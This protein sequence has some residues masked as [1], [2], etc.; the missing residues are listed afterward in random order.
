[1]EMQQRERYSVLK[2]K[3]TP[4]PKKKKSVSPIFTQIAVS[5]MLIAIGFG[6]SAV[7]S[8]K[9]KPYADMLTSSLTVDGDLGD[10]SEAL[11]TFSIN[12]KKISKKTE[13]F[14]PLKG[15]TITD[16]FGQRINPVTQEESFHYGVDLAAP[17]G[18]PIMSATDGQAVYCG[19]DAYYGNY[20]IIK[21]GEDKYTVYGHCKEILIEEGQDIKAGDTIGTVGSSGQSTGNHLHFGIKLDGEYVDPKEYIKL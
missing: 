13:Y 17:E 16:D 12:L 5:L 21:H 1:M 20:I 6:I 10:I 15:G 2:G 11:E 18:T 3:Y 7:K 4:K 8:S 19:D 14:A 9:T